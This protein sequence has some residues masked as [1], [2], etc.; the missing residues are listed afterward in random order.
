VDNQHRLEGS[1]QVNLL[2][3]VSMPERLSIARLRT[4]LRFRPPGLDL[5]RAGTFIH[6]GDEIWSF[7]PLP[8]LRLALGGLV[9]DGLSRSCLRLELEA[10]PDGQKVLSWLLR[11]H[12]EQYLGR[13]AA[14]GLHLERDPAA[15]RAFFRGAQGKVGRLSY[16]SRD[17]AEAS[18]NVVVQRC[19]S[20]RPWFKKTKGSATAP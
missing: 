14:T 13:F 18:R 6:N 16:R 9:D 10:T 1:R 4:A 15:P 7:T 5:T 12:F 11:K 20:R 2:P 17:G 8:A 19:G 3:F